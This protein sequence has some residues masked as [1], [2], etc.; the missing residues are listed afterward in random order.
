MIFCE[1]FLVFAVFQCNLLTSLSLSNLWRSQSLIPESFG[2]LTR[3][4]LR[5]RG[6]MCGYTISGWALRSRRVQWTR[7][8]YITI[9]NHKGDQNRSTQATKGLLIEHKEEKF[10]SFCVLG[11]RRVFFFRRGHNFVSK[12]NQQATPCSMSHYEWNLSKGWAK[13]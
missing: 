1:V 4:V 11:E 9:V 8:N 12:V 7:V 3:A 6:M 13:L 2:R 5:T 10:I